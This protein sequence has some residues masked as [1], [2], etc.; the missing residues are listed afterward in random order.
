MM[1]RDSGVVDE[2]EEL[3]S[4][5]AM[6]VVRLR[7]R[8]TKTLPG[9]KTDASEAL[10]IPTEGDVRV[11]L[12]T[13]QIMNLEAKDV[14]YLPRDTDYSVGSKDGAELVFAYAPAER[15]LAPYVKRFK[16]TMPIASGESTYKRRIYTMVGEKDPANRFIAGFVEG[17]S[18][19][20]T[21][22]PPHKHDGKPEVYIYYGMG[23]R[24]GIQV[25]AVEEELAF[26]V[27]QGDAVFF[28]KGYHPNVATPG[29]GMNFVWI[30]S[31]D[32]KARNLAVDLH[33]EY[34]DLP[35]GQ[36]HLTAK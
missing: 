33:P 7:M 16:E 26:V 27:R 30:I 10:L 28:E 1:H 15:K 8:K 21:S 19:N 35:M 36:T 2:F 3:C 11:S 4:I 5:P 20:W 18:G 9:L 17:D 25:V 32:P 24:F 34:K 12:G 22:F 23:R 13:G 29:I 14:C 31:A 6:R